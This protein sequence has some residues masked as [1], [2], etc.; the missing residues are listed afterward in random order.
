MFQEQRRQ[1]VQIPVWLEGDLI[2]LVEQ[3]ALEV[4]WPDLCDNTSLDEGDIVR[5]LRRTLDF[6]S[7]IPHV[8]YLSEELRSTARQAAYLINRFPVNETPD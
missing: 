6:L 1:D 7:Q 3:W 4:D 8:P 5:F 2:S